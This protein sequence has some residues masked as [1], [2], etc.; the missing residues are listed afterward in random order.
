M[1]KLIVVISCLILSMFANAQNDAEKHYKLAK[2][3]DKNGD[4]YKAPFEASPK[5]LS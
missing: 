3:Y 2:E 5:Q 1:N 4:K